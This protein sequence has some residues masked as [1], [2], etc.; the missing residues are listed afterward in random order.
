MPAQL[1]T[2]FPRD[3]PIAITILSYASVTLLTVILFFLH[4][5][6]R[7]INFLSA[8]LRSQSSSRAEKTPSPTPPAPEETAEP[9]IEVGSG[10]P[11][12]EFLNED[13]F[14]RTLPKKEQFKAYRK[15]RAAKG[16]NWTQNP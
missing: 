13:P 3:F 12:E 5:M 7:Q 4:R 8:R 15:W 11:F 2:D 9:V 6:N 1:P 14:H 16:L 10:T